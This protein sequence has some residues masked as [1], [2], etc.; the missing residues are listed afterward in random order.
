MYLLFN[1]YSLMFLKMEPNMRQ[2][3]KFKKPIKVLVPGFRGGIGSL[4]A[5]IKLQHFFYV[6]TQTGY[7]LQNPGLFPKYDPKQAWL[8]FTAVAFLL[9]NICSHL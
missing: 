5:E 2:Q 4:Q 6:L 7:K 1:V 3:N 9:G 8:S